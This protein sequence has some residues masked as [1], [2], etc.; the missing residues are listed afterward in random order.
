MPIKYIGC[1]KNIDLHLYE[2][3]KHQTGILSEFL[4]NILHVIQI[5]HSSTKALNI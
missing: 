2:Y 1:P 4:E 3:E 5:L